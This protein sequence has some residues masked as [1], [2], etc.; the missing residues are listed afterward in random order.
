MPEFEESL[1]GEDFKLPDEKSKT[2]KIKEKI[3]KP[4]NAEVSTEKQIKSKR[5]SIQ[6]KL[7]LIRAEVLRVLGKQVNNVICIRDKADLDNYITRAIATGR[8]AVDTETNNTTDTHTC[9]L[10]GACFY[11]PGEKQVY[12]PVNHWN[13]ETHIK[14]ENQLTENDI[15]EAL[16]RVVDANIP[17]IMHHADF[18]YQ[19]IHYTCGIDLP[20]Y[21]DTMLAAQVLNEN[22]EASLKKQYISKIDPEQEKYDINDLFEGV[23][24]A[25]VPPEVFALYAATDSL[26]TDRLYEW[27]AREFAK[28][29]NQGLY[30]VFKDVEMPVMPV[31]AKMEMRGVAVDEEFN[32]R[33]SSKY[34]SKLAVCDE[35]IAAELVKLKPDIDAWRLSKEANESSRAYA[36]KKSKK[37]EEELAEQYPF[38]DEKGMRYKQGKALA[39][40]LPDEIN[41][42]SPVQLAI[43]LYN[44]LK[45]PVVDK[46][47]PRATGEDALKILADKT[48]LPL[49]NLLI[50]R[51][52]L[53]KLLSTYID[54]IPVLM[55]FWPDRHV[56]T[57]FR[58]YGA[59]TGRFS[60]GGKVKYMNEDCKSCEI[61]SVNMQNIPAGQK[62]LRMQFK[63]PEGMRLV[64]SD[65]SAQEV[66]MTA[67]MTQDQGMIQA[68]KDGKDLYAVV[69]SNMYDNDYS[70]NL[71]FYPSGKKIVFE[72]NEIIC[73]NKTHLNKEGKARRQSA[74]SV[75]IGLLYGRGVASIA[76]QTGKTVAEAQDIVDRFFKAY[77]VVEKWINNTHEK[78][79]TLGYVEDW[80]GRRRRLPDIQL[81]RFELRFKDPDKGSG[82]FNPFLGCTDRV[83]ETSNKLLNKYKQ[84]LEESHSLKAVDKIKIEAQKDGIEIHNN[85]GFIAQ[86]ERQS[87]NAIIQ[88][89]SST[90]TK[91]AMINVDK[92]VRLKALGFE[93]LITVHDELI[94]QCPEENAEAVAE[95]LPQI[96]IDTAAQYINV[97][98]KCDPYIVK[99]WYEDEQQNALEE[100]YKKSVGKGLS[101]KE[102]YE[103]LLHNHTEMLETEV[104][105]IIKGLGD[106][107]DILPP[108]AY[109]EDNIEEMTEE[110]L[111]ALNG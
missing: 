84:Q 8:I 101:N 5:I 64:G 31:V 79:R 17:I 10:M 59:K 41:L 66:R 78:A 22:E 24:Y 33:L 21:W 71:E 13:P 63:A 27:Q 107:S 67:F 106:S 20:V 96:M 100:E 76:E 62:E 11:T 72:G 37:R 93:L 51:R 58:Q 47:Q 16:Q 52:G 75:L 55:D 81:P 68:Y 38:V 74:K 65:F 102:A 82:A 103:K 45:V 36:P 70:D 80:Y 60:S 49:C 25:D 91:L 29:D 105:E 77:P 85:G 88:G 34:Q 4:K 39:E 18:D 40:Q 2:K 46:K 108:E 98:F 6:E 35:A 94:G 48:K 44:I 86:A 111:E 23:Y 9:R 54:N 69:A 12:I 87:V 92:D 50:E 61:S 56:H 19:V 73:G 83:D 7:D 104:Y 57:H 90:L 42:G 99:R 15:K 14:L 109:E 110:E 30:R 89:G 53:V 43:L 32:R 28:P 97:P 26:M 1:W 95:I 3:A